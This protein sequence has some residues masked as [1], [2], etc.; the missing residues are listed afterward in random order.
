M[1]GLPAVEVELLGE[2]TDPAGVRIAPG[3]HRFDTETTL[4]PVRSVLVR[5]RSRRRDDR[6]RLPLGAEGAAGLPRRPPRPAAPRGAD[7]RQRRAARGV[8]RERHLL[9]DER[10]VPRRA[11]EGPRRHLA[12][13]AQGPGRG[14]HRAVR[15]GRAGRDPPLVRPRGAPR[16]RGLRRRPLPALPGNHEGRLARRRRRRRATAGEMLLFGGAICDARFSKCCGGLTGALRHRLGRPGDSLPRLLPRRPDGAGPTDLD[17]FIRSSPAAFCNTAD[18]GLLARILPGFDQETRDFFRW[19]VSY[20]PDELGEL[21]ASRLGVDLGPITA[22]EPLAR[23]PSGRI[24][25]LRI[26]GERGT[27]VVGKELEIRRALSRSHLYSS[28]FVVD[29]DAAGHF[30]LHRRRLG[31]RCRPLPDRGRGHGG[32]GIRLPGDPRALLPGDDGRARSAARRAGNRGS[33]RARSQRS[34]GGRP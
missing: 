29:R 30:V 27:L 26:T 31:A 24:F 17:A 8:R 25:R 11:P 28:A 16:L 21:V 2:F 19:T 23:G 3:R 15:P 4:T 20:T 34:M 12:Q 1:E 14:R 6:H 22:L 33:R 32:E 5:F 7:G 9:G 13:L 10:D 18:A